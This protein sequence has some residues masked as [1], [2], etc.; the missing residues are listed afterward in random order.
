MKCPD[1]GYR[2]GY[3]WVEG[4]Y[5]EAKGDEGEFWKLPIKLERED[6][7]IDKKAYVFGCPKCK[8]LFWE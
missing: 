5:K 2:N 1:C 6:F 3:D 8:T 7:G 4:E